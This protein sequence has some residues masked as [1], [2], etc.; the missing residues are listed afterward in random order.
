MLNEAKIAHEAGEMK[1]KAFNEMERDCTE[2]LDELDEEYRG[3]R[4]KLI[5]L[6]ADE[7]VWEEFESGQELVQRALG[8]LN[9]ET[10]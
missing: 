10:T 2:K 6:G 4:D 1:S 7:I 9:I 5:S 3:M 8:R